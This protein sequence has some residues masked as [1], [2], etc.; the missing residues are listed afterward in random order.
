MNGIAARL[1]GGFDSLHARGTLLIFLGILALECVLVA[2]GW[3]LVVA[4]LVQRSADD[5]AALMVRVGQTHAS[6]AQPERELFLKQLDEGHHVRVI[7][8]DAPLRG[9]A[10]WLP[11]I[12]YLE[13]ALRRHSGQPV[14]VLSSGADYVL[15][16]PTP[17]GPLRLSFPQRRIGT[18]PLLT[19]GIMALLAL[20]SSLFIAAL[21]ARALTR[22]LESF[23][24]RSEQIRRGEAPEPLPVHGALEMRRL[25][26]RFNV[27]AEEVRELLDDRTVMLA[28]LSHDLRAPITRARMA[29][30][31]AR[32]GMETGLH[33]QLERAIG[34]LEGMT[35]QY[36]EFS[37][38]IRRDGGNGRADA[39]VAELLETLPAGR[40]V[41]ELD[42][43]PPGVAE[44]AYRRCARNLIDNALKHGGDAPVLVRL[45]CDVEAIILEVS[46]RG[47]GIP[48]AERDRVFRPFVRLDPA[49]AAPGSGLGL[50]VV[51]QICGAQGW[52]SELLA[53][54]GGGTCARL[55]VP[56]ARGAARPS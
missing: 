33:A 23:L 5:L 41:A 54:E 1:R 49:R 21:L 28:G 3:L 53:R 51:R 32:P 43:C 19:L 31:L 26:T 45:T 55:T 11:Y 22:P 24:S 4:P 48:V 2:I 12:H 47:P 17:R 15:D 27:L 25:A 36:L 6:L 39:I 44:A 46:D 18:A 16:L 34:E 40:A 14:R 56:L 38:G 13:A 9:E 42:A 7:R 20:V 29:L 50:S 10:A 30:E 37:A 52:R 35:R 8:A